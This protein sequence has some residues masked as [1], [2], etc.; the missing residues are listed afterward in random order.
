M[1]MDMTYFGLFGAPG[2]YVRCSNSDPQS[3]LHIPRAQSI[4]TTYF[5]DIKYVYKQDQGVIYIYI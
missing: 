5:G 4:N 1:H 3:L 2:V